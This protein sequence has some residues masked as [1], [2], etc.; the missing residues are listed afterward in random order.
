MCLLRRQKAPL[1]IAGMNGFL[2]RSSDLRRSVG[3]IQE[4]SPVIYHGASSLLRN[5]L[6][7]TISF[8]CVCNNLFSTLEGDFE[9]KIDSL[10]WIAYSPTDFNPETQEY[11]TGISIRED[12]KTLSNAGFNGLITYSLESILAEIPKIAKESGFKAVIMGIWDIHSQRELD[13]AIKM[14]EYADGYCVGNEGINERRYEL[15]ELRKVIDYVKAKTK[16]PATT[17]EEIRQY[18]KQE[19]AAVGDWIFPNAHPVL[20]NVK[21]PSK[22]VDWIKNYCKIVTRSALGQE[23]PVLFKEI[24]YPTA[25]DNVCNEDNQKEFFQLMENSEVNFAYFEAFDQPW[26]DYLP[27]EPHWGVFDSQRLPKRFI[28]EKVSNPHK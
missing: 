12:L 1:F 5:I 9:E 2:G 15:E 23:K 26:K 21:T 25:G 7:T 18:A 20:Y 24:G 16:L 4:R 22:A 13:N 11:P 8:F 28:A 17:S 3:T 6:I 10:K 19:V 14:R 27:F